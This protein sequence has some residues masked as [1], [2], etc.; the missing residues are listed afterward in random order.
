MW[1]RM[2][3]C[4]ANEIYAK[5]FSEYLDKEFGDKAE[6]NI[7]LDMQEAFSFVESNEVDIAL[8]DSNFEGELK[9]HLNSIKCLSIVLAEN[10][11]ETEDEMKRVFKY[12]RGDALYKAILEVYSTYGKVRVSSKR[13]EEKGCKVF[14]FISP[15]G[16]T[17]CTTIA[18][19]YAKKRAAY[20]KVLYLNLQCMNT[21]WLYSSEGLGL[22]DIIM[23]LKSRRNILNIKLQSA[24]ITNAAHVYTYAP[25]TNPL[26]LIDLNAQDIKNLMDGL[27][28]LDFY[29][30]IIIDVGNQIDSKEIELI[31]QADSII[32]V[33][34]NSE[35]EIKQFDKLYSFLSII[36]KRDN[37]RIIRKLE[38]FKNKVMKNLESH[39]DEYH[40]KTG[41][42][43]PY[44]NKQ[45]KQNG[46]EIIDRI[47][48]SDSFE[49]LGLS[50]GE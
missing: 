8:F 37:L 36:Q 15:G 14:T 3:L 26:D 29:S 2:L 6:V 33:V 16:G 5:R 32:C 30:K 44:V 42:W 20:E 10:M 31:K 1:V 34:D 46:E 25:C 24:V 17:G 11:Y 35:E 4:T 45:N 39:Y 28:A 9:K 27:K 13:A 19:A 40:I 41:G 38:I 7:V 12:Q 23:A 48:Y 50:H 21:E 47:V 49:S 43:A 18:K 22:D